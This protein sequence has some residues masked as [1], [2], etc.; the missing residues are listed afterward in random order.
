MTFAIK[1]PPTWLTRSAPYASFY[2]IGWAV[3]YIVANL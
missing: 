3:G 1:P 2:V